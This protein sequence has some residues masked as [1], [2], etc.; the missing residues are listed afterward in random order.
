[1]LAAHRVKPYAFKGFTPEQKEQVMHERACQMREAEMTKKQD[2]EAERLWALQ[3][4]HLRRQQILADRKHKRELRDVAAGTR[5]TQEAQNAEFKARTK[6]LYNE[7]TPA[8]E[9]K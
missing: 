9:S 1:M 2:K 4:E 7:K 5:A 3:Q 6:D 8:F